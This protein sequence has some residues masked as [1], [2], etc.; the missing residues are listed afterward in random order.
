MAEIRLQNVSKLYGKIV[1]LDDISLRVK[2]R[3]SVVLLGPS[4]CGKTTLLRCIAGLERINNGEI[5]IDG[6]VVNE[7]EPRERDLSMVF[8][9][10][11]LFP[12]MNVY[13]NI[14]FPLKIRHSSKSEIDHR[15]REVA[16]LLQIGSLLKKTP[17]Q[18]S[19]GEQQ[20]VAI[21]RAIAREPKAFLMDEPLSN[22]DTP[23]RVQMRTE[24]KKIQKEIGITTIYVTHD[25]AEAMVLADRIGVMLNGQL[26]Q[27]D[28]PGS[29]Y[30]QP[31]NSFV[32][33][34]IGNPSTNIAPV[35]L[36][37]TEKEGKI[38]NYLVG[39]GFDF[40]V[41][42]NL[43]HNLRELI[44]Y[45]PSKE[46]NLAI[47]P[48]DIQI[49]KKGILSDESKHVEADIQLIEPLGSTT[50]I[51]V[52]IGKGLLFKVSV[53]KD[54]DLNLGDHVWLKFDEAKVHLFDKK[55]GNL[56]L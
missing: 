40:P 54:F 23:L 18:L 32:A 26:L 36:T 3:E 52:K 51:D 13:D 49:T 19:G 28:S 56:L 33:T 37:E 31:A 47:R 8:Q 29:V 5:L 14:G 46:L 44:G 34:F 4:G 53:P 25:Q 55:T 38:V 50:L 42:E 9:T 43:A 17:R 45:S 10:Y 15:V 12:L 27:Y 24:L 11:A 1:A 7:F 22:L 16:N 39:E 48:E 41:S 30:S 20:R 2:D 6:E 21:G 35:V